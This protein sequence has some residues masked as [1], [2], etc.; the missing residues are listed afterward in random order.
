[1]I[2]LDE[3]IGISKTG[4]I[5]ISK[6]EDIDISKTED[7]DSSRTED[8]DIS[9]TE[10]VDISKDKDKAT[11]KDKDNTTTKTE[12]NDILDKVNNK[13]DT[14]NKSDNL[15][16]KLKAEVTKKVELIYESLCELQDEIYSDDSWLRLVELNK[17]DPIIDEALNAVW[18]KFRGKNR[19][20]QK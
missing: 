3:D 10:D 2:E 18:K 6:T 14:I 19:I 1:M 5:D 4:G 17:T 13:I 12:D 7:I 16:A 9:K 20:N 15:L 8:I 11:P